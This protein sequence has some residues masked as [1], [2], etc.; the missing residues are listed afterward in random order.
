MS[1]GI[2]LRTP[3]WHLNVFYDFLRGIREPQLHILG[4]L[5]L[6][7]AGLPDYPRTCPR[8]S[9][10]TPW[11]TRQH[12]RTFKSHFGMPGDVVLE[13]CGC[14]SFSS[15]PPVMAPTRHPHPGLDRSSI[16]ELQ[17][18]GQKE[19]DASSCGVRP[20]IFQVHQAPE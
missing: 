10:G 17:P 18:E 1:L 6:G 14:E 4:V 2:L 16:P 5:N 12:R 3:W 11:V 9:C 7:H 15:Y 8:S 20:W 13:S 19:S